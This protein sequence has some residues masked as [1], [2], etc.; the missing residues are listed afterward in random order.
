MVAKARLNRN[1]EQPLGNATQSRGDAESQD[2][3]SEVPVFP[4][5]LH[6]FVSA[7]C[8]FVNR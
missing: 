4:A 3:S 5:S 6:L 8:F 2:A 1:R 7:L